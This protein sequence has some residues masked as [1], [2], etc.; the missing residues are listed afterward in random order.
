MALVRANIRA[1]LLASGTL[2]AITST[3]IFDAETFDSQEGVLPDAVRSSSSGSILP[4]IVIR[5]HGSAASDPG[6]LPQAFRRLLDIYF[7]ANSGYVTVETMKILTK[8]LLREKFFSGDDVQVCKC[9]W[10]GDLG[11]YVAPEMDHAYADAATFQ[12]LGM[13]T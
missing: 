8:Q 2:T 10:A 13:E 12:L 7:Y 6:Y 3:R 5:F 1:T 9:V 11:E 4:F